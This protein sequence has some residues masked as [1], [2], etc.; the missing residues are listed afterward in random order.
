M[1][2]LVYFGLRSVNYMTLTQTS[3]S[4]MLIA[5]NSESKM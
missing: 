3:E 2:I 5:Q 4:K 1:Q